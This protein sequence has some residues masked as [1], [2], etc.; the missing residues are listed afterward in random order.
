MYF[1][2]NI[3]GNKDSKIL[4]GHCCVWGVLFFAKIEEEKKLFREQ[5]PHTQQA[6]I[7]SCVLN[8]EF[9]FRND[10]MESP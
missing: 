6:I 5:H 1:D 7:E 9:S 8:E 2:R 10:K 4:E 3:N